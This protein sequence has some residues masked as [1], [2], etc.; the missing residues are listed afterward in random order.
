ML[1]A[2]LSIVLMAS[3]AYAEAPAG[4]DC[5]LRHLG[6]YQ[7]CHQNTH[8]LYCQATLLLL[9]APAS[10]STHLSMLYFKKITNI[11]SN[12]LVR[13]NFMQRW[14]MLS[15]YSRLGPKLILTCSPPF[16]ICLAA[17]RA[18]RPNVSTSHTTVPLF[19]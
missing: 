5:K 4:F 18:E 16:S 15:R 8:I 1:L 14:N 6:I 2:M 11:F 10:F 12:Q 19:A 7:I 9:V 17:T 3:A 13:L